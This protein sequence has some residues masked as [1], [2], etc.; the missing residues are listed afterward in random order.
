MR[1]R[2]KWPHW[3]T[4]DFEGQVA[5]D[6]RVVFPQDEKHMLLKQARMVYLEEMGSQHTSVRS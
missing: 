2:I 3:H 1:N 5:V 6:M 4:L